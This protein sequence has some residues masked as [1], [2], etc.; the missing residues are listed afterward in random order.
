MIGWQ[1]SKERAKATKAVSGMTTGTGANKQEGYEIRVAKDLAEL[2]KRWSDNLKTEN[3]DKLDHFTLTLIPDDGIWKGHPHVFDI[4]IDHNYPIKAPKVT[5][6]T[7]CFHPNIDQEGHVCLNILREDWNPVLTFNAIFTGLH[8]L[9]LE[10]NTNDPLD[11][12][13]A[14]MYDKDFQRFKRIAQNYMRGNYS[15]Y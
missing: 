2:E 1:K 10:P 12:E 3:V 11:F 8:F 15:K 4:V 6:K 13:A 5:C 14:D 7:K 9:F